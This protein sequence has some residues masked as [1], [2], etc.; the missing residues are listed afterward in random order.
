MGLDV[1]IDGTGGWFDDVISD[2][3][4]PVPTEPWDEEAD[5]D[6]EEEET[7]DDP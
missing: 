7:N 2:D 6:G 5:G 4:V 3:S 1:E